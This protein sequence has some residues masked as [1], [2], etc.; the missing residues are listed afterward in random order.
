MN[1]ATEKITFH[2]GDKVTCINTLKLEG[3][4]VAPHLELRKIYCV[5]GI[6]YDAKGNQHIDVGLK[7]ELN[8]VRSWETKEKLP[9]GDSIHWCH[10]SRFK[11]QLT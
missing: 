10:P 4:D 9:N 5:M 8:F 7:S 2:L 1:T 11:I 6:C 3:N